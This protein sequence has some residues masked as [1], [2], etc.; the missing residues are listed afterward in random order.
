MSTG[1]Y[2]HTLYLQKSM[3]TMKGQRNAVAW[4]AG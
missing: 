2:T 1:M 3:F 4:L